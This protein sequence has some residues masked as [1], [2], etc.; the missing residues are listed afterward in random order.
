VFANE[1]M[2]VSLSGFNTSLP[3]LSATV[4]LSGGALTS[5]VS[6]GTASGNGNGNMTLSAILGN[7]TATTYTLTATTANGNS[8]SSSLTIYARRI[9]LTPTSA[10]AT[11]TVTVTGSG[12]TSAVGQ[13]IGAGSILFFTSDLLSYSTLSPVA[14][15][16]VAGDGSFSVQFVVPSGAASGTHQVRV[17]TSGGY[18]AQAALTVP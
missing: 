3:E 10:A 6:L 12:F 17:T 5:P 16:T 15:T 18:I 4:E 1:Q 13:S 9:A 2:I 14:A 8:A 7:L 11:T